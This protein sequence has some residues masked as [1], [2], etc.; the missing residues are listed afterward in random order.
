MTIH[1]GQ[2]STF[3][4][5]EGIEP[6]PTLDSESDSDLTLTDIMR[7]TMR[8]RGRA[9]RGR[10]VI[11]SDEDAVEDQKDTTVTTSDVNLQN[12]TE[13]V[14]TAA[15][16]LEKHT[17]LTTTPTTPNKKRAVPVAYPSPPSTK[18]RL[19]IRLSSDGNEKLEVVGIE[20]KPSEM[21]RNNKPR[22]IVVSKHN[23]VDDVCLVH[24]ETT[25]PQELWEEKRFDLSSPRLVR[26]LPLRYKVVEDK[27]PIT[28]G[29]YD[30]VCIPDMPADNIKKD[31][32]VHTEHPKLRWGGVW[33]QGKLAEEVAMYERVKKF[34]LFNYGYSYCPS[35]DCKHE[36]VAVEFA[37]EMQRP[38]VV[39]WLA[40][41]IGRKD[42]YLILDHLEWR[43][44]KKLEKI[45]KIEEE[46][47]ED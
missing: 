1:K 33:A 41:L 47:V 38:R 8:A 44:T 19:R 21:K 17:N 43:M 30:R 3:H 42:V 31:L 18:K 12:R 46:Q 2:S 34:W 11:S 15:I 39:A 26:P 5:K 14:T 22:P 25:T 23:Y 28:G 37:E 32:V 24:H 13:T 36:F 45:E 7:K 27:S 29:F 16:D 10:Q 40:E 20:H 9:R 6:K 35:W 4:P